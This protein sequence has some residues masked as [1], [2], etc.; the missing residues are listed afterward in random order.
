MSILSKEEAL[1]QLKEYWKTDSLILE[2]KYSKS[3]EGNFGFFNNLVLKGSGN[4]LNY[5]N[6][7]G[8]ISAFTK[9]IK[10]L[11]D[12]AYYEF[13]VKIAEDKFRKKNPYKLIIDES[14]SP[15]LLKY[16][17]PSKAYID[18]LFYQKGGVDPDGVATIASQLT[19]NGLEL[20]TET[21]RFIFE[22]LQNADDM[23]HLGEEVIV[24]FVMTEN[25]FLFMHNGKPFTRND[26]NAISDAARS[27]KTDDSKKTGYKGIGF[28]SVFTDSECVY[29]CSN[30]FQFRYDKKANIYRKFDD[31][32]KVYFDRMRPEEK[33]RVRSEFNG[34]EAEFED[35]TNI[36]WQIKP[37]WT[38]KKEFPNEIS[39]TFYRNNVAIALQIGKDIFRNKKYN[40][41]VYNLFKEPRFLLFLR[42]IKA[43]NITLQKGQRIRVNK[44]VNTKNNL[45]E[46]KADN[47]Q[48]NYALQSF[49]IDIDSDSLK[50]VGISISIKN[51]KREFINEDK[52][53]INNIPEKLIQLSKTIIV[54]A[55]QVD[56]KNKIVKAK[57][58]IL[59]NYLPT[60][61]KNYDF[62]FLVNADFV[63]KTDRE[64]ILKENLWNHYLFFHIGYNHVKWVASLASEERANSYLN[65]LVSKLKDENEDNSYS[66]INGYFN[67][68]FQKAINE[69]PFVLTTTNELKKVSEVIIDKS[70]ISDLFE[71]D[72]FYD[73]CET[74]LYLIHPDISKE[75]IGKEVFGVESFSINDLC[76]ILRT[77]YGKRELYQWVSK[78]EEEKYLGFLEKINSKYLQYNRFKE[79]FNDLLI[80]KFDDEYYSINELINKE[81]LLLIS[82][83]ILSVKSALSKLFTV[84][85]INISEYNNISD[86]SQATIP[87]FQNN[88]LLD[89]IETKTS[90][91]NELTKEERKQ[92]FDR[93]RN[94]IN[95]D[96]RMARFEIFK[97][98]DGKIQPLNEMISHQHPEWLNPYKIGDEILDDLNKFF[99]NK[100]IYS[101]IIIP[102]WIDII[103]N[104]IIDNVK[105]KAFYEKVVIYYAKD[106]KSNK[107]SFSDS[108]L[109]FIYN[110]EEFITYQKTFCHTYFQEIS[111]NKYKLFNSILS[112]VSDSFSLAQYETLSVY[113]EPPF[114]LNNI[115]KGE[116]FDKIENDEIRIELELDEVNELFNFDN[117]LTSQKAIF[118]NTKNQFKRLIELLSNS[119]SFPYWLD[120]Y[121]IHSDYQAFE[122]F[123]KKYMISPETVYSNII[124]TNWKDIIANQKINSNNV[125]A[126]YENI[127]IYYK[128]DLKPD[129]YVF[130]SESDFE[131]IYTG[132]KF[133]KHGI[134]YY[135]EYLCNINKE[136][137]SIFNSILEK[138]NK[139]YSPQF[140][141]LEIYKKKPFKIGNDDR[142]HI[143]NDLEK[144]EI[145][146]D[147]TIKEIHQLFKYDKNKTEEKAIFRN[148]EGEFKIL[149]ELLPLSDYFVP[150]WLQLFQINEEFRPYEEEL[151]IKMMT[152]KEVYVNIILEQWSI[153][154]NRIQNTLNEEK[155]VVREVYQ[156]ITNFYNENPEGIIIVRDKLSISE[157]SLDFIYTNQK[158]GFLLKE[159]IFYNKNYR[160]IE[161]YIEILSDKI[162]LDK[163]II[164]YLINEEVDNLTSPFYSKDFEYVLLDNLKAESTFDLDADGAKALIEYCKKNNEALFNKG[165]FNE[166]FQFIIGDVK[167]YFIPKNQPKF[168]AYVLKYFS[169]ILVH[170]PQGLSETT[171]SIGL[172][173][174][175]NLYDN[176][177]KNLEGKT[178]EYFELLDIIKEENLISEKHT[179]QTY[180]NKINRLDFK[181][182][183]EGKPNEFE[184]KYIKLYYES[185]KDKT[186]FQGKIS[187]LRDMI[188][189]DDIL[190]SEIEA[191]PQINVEQYRFEYNEIIKDSKDNTYLVDWLK[192]PFNRP[193]QDTIFTTNDEDIEDTYKIFCDAYKSKIIDINQ[194]V[195]LLHY[196]VNNLSS[197]SG[198]KDNVKLIKDF[199]ENNFKVSDEF[200]NHINWHNE[201]YPID[202]A[203]DKE[204]LSENLLIWI[205]D[206]EK[207][208]KYLN[209]LGLNVLNST[210]VKV[211][212][213]FTKEVIEFSEEET[214]EVLIARLKQNKVLLEN[215]LHWL[216]SQDITFLE[217]ADKVYLENLK[218]IYEGIR[219]ENNHPI[220]VYQLIEK[221]ETRFGFV[222]ND[223]S[224]RFTEGFNNYASSTIK[225]NLLNAVKEGNECLIDKD[226]FYRNIDIPNELEITYKKELDEISINLEAEW[227]SP[228]YIV[229][230]KINLP[231]KIYPQS[232]KL[233]FWDTFN[234]VRIKPIGNT[235]FYHRYNDGKPITK[236]KGYSILLVHISKLEGWVDG[237]SEIKL[238]KVEEGIIRAAEYFDIAQKYLLSNKN[239]SNYNELIEMIS[240]YQYLL[241]ALIG[242][243]VYSNI[244]EAKNFR[245]EWVDDLQL[246]Y[247]KLTWD[248]TIPLLAY[249]EENSQKK[250]HFVQFEEKVTYYHGLNEVDENF[251]LRVLKIIEDDG[252]IALPNKLFASS[253]SYNP[254]V[255]EDTLDMEYL[256]DTRRSITNEHY[257]NQWPNRTK[258]NYQIYFIKGNIRNKRTFLN[259][260]MDTYSTPDRVHKID[261]DIYLSSN[262]ENELETILRDN[263]WITEVEFEEL[264]QIKTDEYEKENKELKTENEQ[265]RQAHF[266]QSEVIDDKKR[267]VLTDNAYNFETGYLGE[268]FVHEELSKSE[269][270]NVIWCNN[271]DESEEEWGAIEFNDSIYYIKD[272]RE[273]YDLTFEDDEGN[274]NYVQVK[275]TVTGFGKSDSIKFPISVN[276]WSFM[277]NDTV[278]EY[279]YLARVFDAR[280]ESPSLRLIKMIYQSL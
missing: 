56:K 277:E 180:L 98:N 128:Q 79:I 69:I 71:V 68:G 273:P 195:F 270:K 144:D 127:I 9:N 212:R 227:D 55:A 177:I 179:T 191:K 184:V 108:E 256:L 279:Y 100:R 1:E 110:G 140:E 117:K 234:N 161:D 254:I 78:L 208:V 125:K 265:L 159:D 114:K 268:A 121:K 258:Y 85:S 250:Y 28:K 199:Y 226:E 160:V 11:T 118:R 51:E 205:N 235:R 213:Y 41:K 166:E 148:T 133:I 142:I 137:F 168:A 82:N 242:R 200:K 276:E 225:S 66:E 31:L 261:N 99:I 181:Y 46:I 25:M 29:I 198:F 152:S 167:Q 216:H 190:L 260:K 105:I 75:I 113:L 24:K 61:D 3:T 112:K 185:Y 38:E 204:S 172:L 215:T 259:H 90:K 106:D 83:D 124:T 244:K 139:L 243:V 70:E 57:N 174:G 53:V 131:F 176:V 33:E 62:P 251:K 80:L 248:K 107:F 186:D 147:L 101:K 134:V 194:F 49:N 17:L 97:N 77:E 73:L 67:K 236:E 138:T 16:H 91:P 96:K 111:D 188:Y 253:I 58:S 20:Y 156:I 50:L 206:D 18:K 119:D 162:L 245:K 223:V 241:K 220:L 8:Q 201:V 65:V 92:I 252:N 27:N 76:V 267:E 169:D 6:E 135:D 170:L 26:V 37:I 84:S 87:Y 48:S 272:S 182:D 45:T 40:S 15:K 39:D 64:F 132:T 36:S 123:L 12:E 164:P 163:T 60:S 209:A 43:I 175:S 63:T 263:E 122:K 249:K 239:I 173:K 257:Y 145:R 157:K 217:K 13:K 165:H 7:K 262:Y 189:I 207:K 202:Y 232:D 115:D 221:N 222:K 126:F 171:T 74:D 42:N 52:I 54:F 264:K 193:L 178:I 192:K 150:I 266:G 219:L 44:R 2:G 143:F 146:E 129:K 237:L 30:G 214:I 120:D 59:F 280:S 231:V 197:F 229:A 89:R 88:K 187:E 136:E 95:D 35:V 153:V 72:L 238:T 158:F 203:Y 22:L 32:Y 246:I 21:E 23:P 269:F 103:S 14:Y 218:A 274:I 151:K 116:I 278:R 230:Q 93:L 141:T 102:N 275:S 94:I 247:Q 4:V 255:I 211:R 10:S 183:V 228:L 155:V 81:N 86:I 271:V 5:P 196:D 19:L 210:V 130:S 109:P 233:K 149:K 224:K 154:N 34:R 240:P 104:S 47:H